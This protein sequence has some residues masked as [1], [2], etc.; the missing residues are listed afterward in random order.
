MPKQKI[1]ELSSEEQRAAWR[2]RKTESLKQKRAKALL[3]DRVLGAL[4]LPGEVRPGEDASTIPEAL[5]ASRLFLR[6]AGKPDAQP[7]E[8]LLDVERRAFDAWIETGLHALDLKTGKFSTE[9]SFE[10]P[11]KSFDAVWR[12]LPGAN[13]PLR[14]EQLT[15]LPFSSERN[16]QMTESAQVDDPGVVRVP[17]STVLEDSP[18][19]WEQEFARRR[20][21]EARHAQQQGAKQIEE[22]QRM[23]KEQEAG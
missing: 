16:G 8:S 21:A 17:V 20:E 23:M 2:L 15:P 11:G 18:E 7:G 6:A 5:R 3:Q 1:K 13:T 14:A 9:L 10:N 12:P 4:L 22:V 19:Y